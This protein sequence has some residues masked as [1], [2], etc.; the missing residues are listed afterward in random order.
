ML[1]LKP[2]VCAITQ[3]DDSIYPVKFE[4]IVKIITPIILRRDIE[5]WI[6]ENYRTYADKL[7][8]W[9]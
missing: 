5:D 1:S 6:C 8:G 4:Y 9:R 3:N 7:S 2:P